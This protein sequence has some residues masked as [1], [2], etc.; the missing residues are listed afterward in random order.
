MNPNPQDTTQR[1]RDLVRIVLLITGIT[2][3]GTLRFHFVSDDYPQIVFNP[4]V[5]SW[6]Y[7]PQYFV[8]SVWKM[9]SSWRV[10]NY[11]RPLFLVWTRLNYLMFAGRP[12]GWH[13]TAVL[14]HLIATWLVF[15]VIREM[16]GR[17]DVAWITALIFGVHPIHHEVVAW[18]ASTT[19]S[20][21]GILFLAAFLAYLRSR[22]S[23]K[24]R[25]MATSCGWYALAV[26]FKETAIVLPALVFSHSWLAGD[27]AN[28]PTAP[29]SGRSWW[30][31]MQS[32][33]PYLPIALVYLV[34][35]YKALSGLSHPVAIETTSEWF[36]TLPSILTWYVKHWLLPIR[37]AVYYDLTYQNGVSFT[38]VVVPVVVLLAIG[39]AI[40][41]VRNRLGSREVGYAVAWSV[42]P[43][44]PALDT[45]VF[46]QYD[47]VHDRYFYIPSIGAA[48]LL[49][50]FISKV[51]RSPVATFG[52]PVHVV[53]AGLG[54]AVL[55]ALVSVRETE[56]WYDD[57]TL[58]TRAHEIAPLNTTA[59]NNLGADMIGRGEIEA[60]QPLLE[61]GYRQDAD[62]RIAFNL[63]RVYYAKKQYSGAESYTQQA[64]AIAPEFP[65]AY[66][67]LGQIQLKLNRPEEAQKSLGR[68]VELNPYS[69]P[70]HTSYGIVLALNGD[71][72]AA[73][74]QF[75][76]ALDL[77][78]G[79]P[80]TNAQLLRCRGAAPPVV[81]KPGQL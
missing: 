13:L 46:G 56:Y 47:L 25:W 3:V 77:N 16:C 23:P 11:Y 69:A 29:K 57:Y 76:A 52:Q 64:L 81:S 74:Q 20:L 19:E 26:L 42:V 49:A 7:L 78:P 38:H 27:Q 31:A 18:V 62:Y 34:I 43:L 55:L 5:K 21:Y 39:L 30:R 32:A 8:S 48:L 36:L 50:L 28:D 40:W 37:L 35:R 58:C 60:A 66:V 45:F 15:R 2:F 12:F 9:S 71:C 75:E 61:A 4:F 10:D 17:S 14:L 51:P 59:T 54:L 1:D 6:K 70:F 79:D 41:L 80:L 44:L 33:A 72:A 22:E 73:T 53:V 65:D 68:A 63:G 67:S 24:A